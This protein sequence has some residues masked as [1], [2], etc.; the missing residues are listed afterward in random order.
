MRHGIHRGHC[1]SKCFTPEDFCGTFLLSTNTLVTGNGSPQFCE[2]GGR[3]NPGKAGGFP[4]SSAWI[5][6]TSGSAID[7]GKGKSA[8]VEDHGCAG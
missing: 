5:F 3:I 1:R 8:V 7:P 6:S 4:L 2:R